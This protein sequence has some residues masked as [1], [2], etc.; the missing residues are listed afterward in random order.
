MVGYGASAKR[1]LLYV[2]L[3][4]AFLLQLFSS[5]ATAPTFARNHQLWDIGS[6][7][8]AL[9]QWL[10]QNG[11]AVAQ[12]GP[13]SRAN[14]TDFFGLRT[15]HSLLEFQAAHHLPAIINAHKRAA[16]FDRADTLPRNNQMVILGLGALGV[17]QSNGDEKRHY[18]NNSPSGNPPIKPCIS[19]NPRIFVDNHSMVRPR[20]SKS[21]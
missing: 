21:Q 12:S 18:Q 16:H 7:I 5:A 4:A 17:R 10:N 19:P 8:L 6:D 3:T 1:R 9:Q 14:E 20:S 2:G 15:Y 11:Y 13:G